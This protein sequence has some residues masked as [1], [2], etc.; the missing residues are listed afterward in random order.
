MLA[1]ILEVGEELSLILNSLAGVVHAERHAPRIWQAEGEHAETDRNR[2]LS[3]LGAKEHLAGI[4]PG[5]G[6]VGHM[7]REPEAVALPRGNAHLIAAL[8]KRRHVDKLGRRIGCPLVEAAG[9]AHIDL[10]RG[11]AR[12]I[13]PAQAGAG[14]GESKILECVDP[15]GERFILAPITA[16]TDMP[17]PIYLHQRPAAD[18]AVVTAPV[19]DNDIAVMRTAGAFYA[20]K[21][22]LVEILRSRGAHPIGPRNIG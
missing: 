9:G 4:E 11:E 14:H 16:K 15:K 2:M 6:I 13:R 22:N 1:H 19:P 12:A 7:H 3:P 17:A 20:L 10:L 21:G 18:G 5:L 8:Q